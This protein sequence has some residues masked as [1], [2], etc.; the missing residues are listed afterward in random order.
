VQID[1]YVLFDG[2]C[3][4]AFTFYQSAL[5]GE[6]Q[7]SRFEGSPMENHVPAGAK[8]KVMH[9]SLSVKGAT[10]MGADF[11]GESRISPGNNI[12]LSLAT[13]DEREADQIFA[14]LSAGGAVK[15]PMAQQFWGAKFGMLTDKF[16]VDWMVSSH[17]S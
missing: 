1:P 12:A 3:E 14:K 16:G 11:V 13:G 10:L 5:G 9:V 2:N 17:A 6:M 4:E 7:I 8:Q 15:M